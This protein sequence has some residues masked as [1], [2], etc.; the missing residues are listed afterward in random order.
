MQ[1][2]PMAETLRPLLPSLRVCILILRL[3]VGPRPVRRTRDHVALLGSNHRPET[4]RSGCSTKPFRPRVPARH[5]LRYCSSLTFSIQS[6]FLP[7]SD[8]VIAICVIAVVAVAP[9]QCFSPGGNQM[10]S[11]GRISS[12]GPPWHCTQPSPDVTMRV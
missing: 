2:K 12:I 10:T 11:P 7:L 9:C 6:T 1:P 3:A 5:H 4:R 8:S